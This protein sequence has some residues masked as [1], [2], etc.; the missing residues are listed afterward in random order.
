M[1]I[2]ITIEQ[3]QNE[4][5]MTLIAT[6]DLGREILLECLSSSEVDDI[7][8]RELKHLFSEIDR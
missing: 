7:S 5:T 8:I 6:D 1:K 2:N 3:D 4:K